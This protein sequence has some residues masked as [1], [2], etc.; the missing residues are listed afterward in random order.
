ML[1]IDPEKC[2]KAAAWAFFFDL[3]LFSCKDRIPEVDWPKKR[4]GGERFVSLQ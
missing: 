1:R 3:D 4:K 2:K